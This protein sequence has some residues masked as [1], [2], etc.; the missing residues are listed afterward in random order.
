MKVIKRK[1]VLETFAWCPKC[2]SLVKS[3]M[4]EQKKKTYKMFLCKLCDDILYPEEVLTYPNGDNQQP[5][6][7]IQRGTGTLEGQ[8]SST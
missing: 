6:T 5:S 7:E 8:D 2:N 1:E 4:E 3:F